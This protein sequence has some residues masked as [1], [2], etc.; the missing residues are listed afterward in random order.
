METLKELWDAIRLGITERITSPL[1]GNFIVSWS[2][3]N[4]RLFVTIFSDGKVE[5]KFR[6]IDSDIYPGSGAY[7]IAFLVPAAA[8][9]FM[10]YG[11]PVLARYVY[12]HRL[13][14]NKDL[15]ERRR[16]V[17]DTEP[18]DKEQARQLRIATREKDQQ[19]LAR[20]AAMEQ[21]NED[22]RRTL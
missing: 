2:L 20:L 8:T 4:Y 7:W 21:E 19:W 9:V 13:K 6:I 15:M 10:I 1:L 17:E 5:D 16:R 12:E 11:Y 22:L 18:M 14:V 3:W